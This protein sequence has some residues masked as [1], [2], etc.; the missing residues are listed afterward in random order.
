MNQFISTLPSE[1]DSTLYKR[2]MCI[3]FDFAILRAHLD[4]TF[5]KLAYHDRIFET[6]DPRPKANLLEVVRSYCGF[7]LH[8][9]I[10]LLGSGAPPSHS[11]GN[12][13][14]DCEIGGAH[15]GY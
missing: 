4:G 9:I 14:D 2:L 1:G 5:P 11:D 8:N 10:T 3:A 15:G 12:V 6:L 7:G 13:F